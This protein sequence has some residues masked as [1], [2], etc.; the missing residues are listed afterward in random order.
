MAS[1]IHTILIYP[2]AGYFLYLIIYRLHPRCHPPTHPT[3]LLTLLTLHINSRFSRTSTYST[4][5]MFIYTYIH[6][7]CVC[8]WMCI[9][10]G[11]VIY[12]YIYTHPHTHTHTHTHKGNQPPKHDAA[13]AGSQLCLQPRRSGKRCCQV[14]FHARAHQG[15]VY[16]GGCHY[17]T[18][19][20]SHLLR[21]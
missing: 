19:V 2:V 9:C 7:L 10:L 8:V 17:D 4:Y 11:L 6:I 5:N 3:P 18:P 1:L 14:H 12:I 20:I 16:D 15:H 21:G 13:D